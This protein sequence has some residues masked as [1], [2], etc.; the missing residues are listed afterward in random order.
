MNELPLEGATPNTGRRGNRESGIGSSVIDR[1]T[2]EERAMIFSPGRRN[3]RSRWGFLAIAFA[4]VWLVVGALQVGAQTRTTKPAGAAA[5]SK[6]RALTLDQCIQI[7][8]KNNAEIKESRAAVLGAQA[9]RSQA[10][11][12]RYPQIEALALLG[13]SA[14]ARGDQVSSPDDQRDPTIDGIFVQGVFTLIQP[15]FTFGE[16]SGLRRAAASNVKV[17][18]AKVDEKSSDVILKVKE[19]YNG[20]LLAR[21]LLSLVNEV[22]GDLDSAK[23]KVRNLLEKDSEQVAETDLYKLEAFS[24]TVETS[25]TQAEKSVRLSLEALK[26]AMGLRA[27]EQ[28]ELADAHILPDVKLVE[29]LPFYQEQS[30]Q[31]RPEFRQIHEGLKA[32]QALVSVEKSKY[33]PKFFVGALAD[34]ADATNRDSIDNP[35][36]IDPLKHEIYGVAVGF[37][38]TF[39]FGITA[40]RISEARAEVQKV[41]HK[42]TFAQQG[43]PLEVRKAYE[44][45]QEAGKNM[46][47]TESSYRFA[48]KW[49][50]ASVA[51]FDLG[52]GDAE[53][54]FRALEQ[55][56]KT[57]AENYKQT[58]TYNMG[59]A[60]LERASGLVMTTIKRS[61]K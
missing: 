15:I 57:R 54:I 25:L 34:L 45:L 19:F 1:T 59:L 5:R 33:F 8:L 12:A 37:R 47:S 40:G 22:K 31:L 56:A 60:N 3:G 49:L 26:F 42:K 18:Q 51:N 38:W 24:S 44:E 16:I 11:A 27:E 43:V 61:A 2:P 10:D 9:K 32:L 39:D 58:F 29:K 50:V 4:L 48:R 52:I 7:A 6:K 23:E 53:E 28:I 30:F 20:H 17:E 46:K 55:Y 21:D 41:Q 35:F 13:P 36:V 14:R